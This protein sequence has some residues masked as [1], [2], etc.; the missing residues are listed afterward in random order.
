MP[1]EKCALEVA[2]NPSIASGNAPLLNFS[3]EVT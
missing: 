2:Y 1:A 3:N